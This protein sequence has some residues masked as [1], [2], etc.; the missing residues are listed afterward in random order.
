[1]NSKFDSSLHFNRV[2]CQRTVS[3]GTQLSRKSNALLAC[4]QVQCP[5][6]KFN[7]LAT[8]NALAKLP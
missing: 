2:C 1:M 8:F 6:A 5:Y 7:A 4:N 3:S